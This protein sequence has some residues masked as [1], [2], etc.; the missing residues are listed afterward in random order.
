ML[1][2]TRGLYHATLDKSNGLPLGL[3]VEADNGN[4]FLLIVSVRKDSLADKWSEEHKHNAFGRGDWI[5]EVNGLAG[6]AREMVAECDAG[7]VLQMCVLRRRTST[8]NSEVGSPRNA[9]KIG[10]PQESYEVAHVATLLPEMGASV[11]GPL[12]SAS[13]KSQR[14]GGDEGAGPE[15]AT[16]RVADSFRD[17]KEDPKAKASQFGAGARAAHHQQLIVPRA[18]GDFRDVVEDEDSEPEDV[19]SDF[20]Q[21]LT[22]AMPSKWV[23]SSP[24][25]PSPAP[26]DAAAGTAARANDSVPKA[27]KTG[28]DLGFGTALGGATPSTASFQAWPRRFRPPAVPSV[29]EAGRA[30]PLELGAA[31]TSPAASFDSLASVGVEPRAR[32]LPDPQSP[33][34]HE[35]ASAADASGFGAAITAATPS[36]WVANE[37]PPARPLEFGA[38]LK[39]ASPSLA[40]VGVGPRAHLIPDPQSP[41]A[42]LSLPLSA[43]SASAAAEDDDDSG[44]GPAITTATP[45]AWVAEEAPPKAGTLDFGDALTAA[46]PSVA[47][48]SRAHA[49]VGSAAASAGSAA[50]GDSGAS[51]TFGAA[52][53]AA[54]PSAGVAPEAAPSGPLD[55]GEAITAAIRSTLGWPVAG[56]SSAGA[57]A[58]PQELGAPV[59][60]PLRSTGGSMARSESPSR[61]ST[62]T[63]LAC[64]EAVAH[65]DGSELSD[66]FIDL[67]MGAQVGGPLVSSLGVNGCRRTGTPSTRHRPSSE[68]DLGTTAAVQPA[69][70][71][72][73]SGER[74]ERTIS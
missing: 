47:V 35:A 12:T 44:F 5:I 10:S 63:Q 23:P 7:Q 2:S 8:K 50:S 70:P 6:N 64:E 72:S 3:E 9:S 37:A 30:A 55:F 24:S 62:A 56:A 40:S 11:A 41:H 53:T 67:D 38:A 54:A 51:M 16:K 39:A 34:S 21:P 4:Q 68:Q 60:G 43:A 33:Q 66:P 57:A 69:A 42:E 32:K 52:I 22:G 28:D 59:Q 27:V 45:S 17:S 25:Q 13:S 15:P 19:D 73:V 18:K 31:L 1:S 48:E 20:G 46:S 29:A 74:Q 71:H 61:A 58:A 65:E 26:A 49:P 36:A 14:S